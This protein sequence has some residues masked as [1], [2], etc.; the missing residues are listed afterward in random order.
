MEMVKNNN[1]IFPNGPS[2][3][4][5]R[6]FNPSEQVRCGNRKSG[7]KDQKSGF[8]GNEMETDMK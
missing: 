8:L 7:Q 6:A 1:K 5:A 4:M 3:S 2:S